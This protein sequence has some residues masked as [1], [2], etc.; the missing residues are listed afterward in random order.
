[1]NMK[2][3]IRKY[4]FAVLFVLLII[5]LFYA[6]I[7]VVG[8]FNKNVQISMTANADFDPPISKSSIYWGLN[9][10]LVENN[11]QRSVTIYGWAINISSVPTANTDIV[12]VLSSKHN[13]YNISTTALRR[14]DIGL[15]YQEQCG[16]Y[17]TDN[18]FLAEFSPLAIEDDIYEVCFLVKEYEIPVNLWC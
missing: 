7:V 1:M 12:V 13:C 16:V 17:K 10:F 2:L 18:G 14:A 11:M 5:W 8:Y 3:V 6:N 9:D 15:L 4:V